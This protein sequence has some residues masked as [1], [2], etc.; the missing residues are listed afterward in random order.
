MNEL[1]ILVVDDSKDWQDVLEIT[2]KKLGNAVKVDLAS[3][4]GEA[5]QL[6]KGNRYSL[7]VVDLILPDDAANQRNEEYPGLALLEEIRTSDRN[8]NCGLIVLTVTDRSIVTRRALR[9]YSAYDYVIKEDFNRDAFIQTIKECIFHTRATLAKER[10]ESSYRLTVTFNHDSLTGSELA[11]PNHRA[12]NTSI[13]PPHFDVSDLAR[14]ADT[15]NLLILRK[16]PD[17]WRQEAKSIGE[18]LQRELTK[19]TSIIN[20]L[21]AARTLAG[22]DRDV[23]LQFSG[24]AAGLGIPFELLSEDEEYFSQKYVLTRRVASL[25]SRKP[26]SFHGF[27]RR[28]HDNKQTLRALVVGANSDGRI[29]LVEKEAEAV[30]KSI[31]EEAGYLGLFCSVDLL[32]G[33][34]ASY[35]KVS[36]A[37][38]DGH[39]HIFHYAGHGRFDDSLPEISGLILQDDAGPRTLTAASLSLLLRGADL[40]LVYLS[41]CLGARS[42]EQVGRGDFHGVMEALARADVP[43]VF[44]HRWSVADDPARQMALAFYESLWSTLLPGEA[45][46]RARNEIAHQGGFDNETW[47]SPVLLVQTM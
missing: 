19:E 2:L 17:F 41:C 44:G 21:V 38:R 11:G 42:S 29:P 22:K 1:R 15:L 12:I 45:M 32:V 13:R 8:R 3:G 37:L 10:S 24:P 33:N 6:I 43:V 20:N 7:A 9:D 36:D 18:M 39:Y 26:E 34:Q 28:L 27:L 14:R 40:R 4:Y 35:A 46:L 5:L 16:V 23:W 25:S 47:A 31:S 30:A